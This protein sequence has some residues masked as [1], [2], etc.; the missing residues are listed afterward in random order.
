MWFAHEGGELRVFPLPPG[1]FS[2]IHD[3][4]CSHARARR[5]CDKFPTQE[6]Y[7]D[8]GVF[9][10]ECARRAALGVPIDFSQADLPKLRDSIKATLLPYRS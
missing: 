5:V 7:H 8:C 10:L 1:G 3:P 2:Q 9:A 4:R 6:N